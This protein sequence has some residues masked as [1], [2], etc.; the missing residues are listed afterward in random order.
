MTE[1]LADHATK[2]EANKMPFGEP[3][4]H[5]EPKTENRVPRPRTATMLHP[6]VLDSRSRLLPMAGNADGMIE[7]GLVSLLDPVLSS[8]MGM[9]PNDIFNWPTGMF[10]DVGHMGENP[11]F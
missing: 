2:M 10:L 11:Q 8:D 1:K 3:L 9:F 4:T 7:N 6:R 5:L